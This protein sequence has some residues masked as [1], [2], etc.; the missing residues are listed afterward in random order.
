MKGLTQK[1]I[2]VIP[3]EETVT[4]VGGEVYT[5]PLSV[6]E[7][8]SIVKRMLKKSGSINDIKMPWKNI[9]I[10][11]GG[12]VYNID[13]KDA[14]QFKLKKDIRN[15][16]PKYFVDNNF[17]NFLKDD[18]FEHHVF[19]AFDDGSIHFDQV[20]MNEKPFTAYN[21]PEETDDK[22]ELKSG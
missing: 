2:G 19:Y 8:V 15:A 17:G 7:S 4:F 21:Q 9:N 6:S 12:N 5:I 13:V 14:I 10:K 11:A 20:K 3:D 1:T 18:F 16:K 22:Y